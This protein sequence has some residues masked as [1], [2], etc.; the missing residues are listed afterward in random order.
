MLVDGAAVLDPGAN[1]FI[2]YSHMCNGFEIPEPGVDFY[3]L[4]DVPHGSVRIENYFSNTADS[5][6]RIFVY[7]PPGY[8]V[9]TKLRYPVLYL[10]HGGGEDQR[11]W[12]EMGRT[13]WILDNLIAAGKAK[14]FIV[15]METSAVGAPVP[16]PGPRTRNARSG[17]WNCASAWSGSR[18][19]HDGRSWWRRLRK[20]HDQR[21]DP[22]GG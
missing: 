14:P 10:Q 4:K 1:T 7:T 18:A 11:V 21:P 13:N 9:N 12:V 3:E 20:A 15:V 22:V 2:G 16:G 5:W 8:D 19:R 17:A 6:R